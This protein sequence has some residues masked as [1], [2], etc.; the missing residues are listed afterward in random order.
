VALAWIGRGTYEA[1]EWEEAL[2]EARHAH[3]NRTAAHLT[4]PPMFAAHLEE[5]LSMV[6]KHGA[7]VVIAVNGQIPDGEDLSWRWDVRVGRFEDTEVVGAGE[8]DTE[9]AVRLTYAGVEHRLVHDCLAAIVSC[10]PGH[11][12]VVANYTAFFQLNRARAR[13]S[14]HG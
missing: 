11:V 1:G 3:N 10:P 5:A 6:D 4:G 12:E 7:G 9:L 14:R 8:R 13:L 2:S